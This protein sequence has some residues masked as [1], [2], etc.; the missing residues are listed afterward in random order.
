[1]EAIHATY[2]FHINPVPS[3]EY[4]ST[5]KY[6][7]T[8]P[9]VIKRPIGR[10]KVHARKRDPAE[11]LIEGNKLKKTFKVTCSKS[12][13]KGHNY[14]TCKGAPANTNRRRSTRK[15]RRGEPSTNTAPLA[16]EIS[17]SAPQV[18]VDDDIGTQN[19]GLNDTVNAALQP[20]EP[21][22]EPSHPS[23]TVCNKRFKAKQPT[24]RR[25]SGRTMASS[26]QASAN[27]AGSTEPTTQSSQQVPQSPVASPSKE[28]LGFR[29]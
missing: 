13:E 20:Q 10:P 18:E 16:T 4:W 14:K 21:V 9:P 29:V 11:V 2:A 3:E 1:M 26:Q 15:K 19:A 27:Q 22:V 25:A 8:N 28:T 6:L 23:S 7:K 5:T 24:R 12:G 17:Q